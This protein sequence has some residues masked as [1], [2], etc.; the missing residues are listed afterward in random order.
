MAWGRCC[1]PTPATRRGARCKAKSLRDGWMSYDVWTAL[2]SDEFY[3]SYVWQDLFEG[4]SIS[5]A[6]Y[7]DDVDKDPIIVFNGRDQERRYPGWRVSWAVGP[8]SVID[9]ITSAGAS[10][11]AA[12]RALQR[13]AVDLLEPERVRQEMVALQ[14]CFVSKRRVMLERLQAMGVRFDL[15]PQ[16]SFYAWGDVGALPEPLNTGMGFFRAALDR[17]VIVVPGEFFDVNPGSG[18]KAAKAVLKTTS[19]SALVPSRR[20]STRG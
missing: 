5:A 10:W 9:A 19:A 4:Q 14:R 16:G 20:C 11:T 6:E 2:L 15:E 8:R 1:S 17:Q 3:G 7:V 12:A 13:A 18:A